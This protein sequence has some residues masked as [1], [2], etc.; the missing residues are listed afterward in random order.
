M[1]R[2]FARRS[3]LVLA[4]LLLVGPSCARS[5]DDTPRKLVDGTPPEAPSVQFEGVDLP[6]VLTRVRAVSAA[7]ADPGSRMGSCFG[8][9]WDDRPIAQA[10]RRVGALGESVTFRGA[11]RNTLS[12]C[13]DS[14]GAS[15][16]ERPWCGHVLGRLV[17]GALR[18]PRLDLGGC[19]TSDGRPVAFAWVTPGPGT[20]F[21]VVHHGEFAEVY[22]VAAG[23]P[24]RVA[25]TS[26]I[27]TTS[28]SATFELSEHA[29]DGRRLR[30]YS[31]EARVAG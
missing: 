31:L 26:G 22:R 11:S 25:T 24:V 27:D 21:V 17:E 4:M 14:A 23:L 5:D 13:D 28:S 6:A 7:R 15:E 20:H 29:D 19:S 2:A 10:V 3:A 16:G 1:S 12:A 8:Q 30:G 18:D 9:G